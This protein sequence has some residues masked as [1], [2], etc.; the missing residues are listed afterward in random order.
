[1]TPEFAATTA[2]GTFSHG[3]VLVFMFLM[4]RDMIWK[5][6]ALWKS[7]NKKQLARFICLFIFNTACILPIIY[8]VF[9]QKKEIKEIVLVKTTKIKT[10]KTKVK[11][12]K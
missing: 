8:L 3:T 7:G 4:V 5:G 11:R 12:G 1:M 9:F 10:N 2:S 6:I